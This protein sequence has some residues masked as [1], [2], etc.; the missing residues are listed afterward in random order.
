MDQ[1][2][3]KGGARGAKGPMFELV[4]LRVL[5]DARG[6][7]I[8]IEA[9]R[10][11]PFPIKRVYYI[12]G[13]KPGVTRGLHAHKSLQQAAICVHGSCV[14]TMDDGRTRETFRLDRPDRALVIRSLIWH[15][16]SEF[17]ADCVLMV[18]ASQHYDEA[19]Y[20]RDYDAFRK[21]AR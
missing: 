19:D 13:T 21:L 16:M 15:E 6:S 2:N 14:F 18:L 7:L 9:E 10:S 3:A 8:A 1:T 11:I 4:D 12:Y 20:I 5:G 17:S